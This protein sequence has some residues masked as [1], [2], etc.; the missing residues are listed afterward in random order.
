MAFCGELY[1]DTLP[2]LSSDLARTPRAGIN[3][4]RVFM[5]NNLHAD[6]TFALALLTAVALIGPGTSPARAYHRPEAE[7]RLPRP[8][9]QRGRHPLA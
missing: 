6:S 3:G 9:R 7:A 5:I 1:P 8:R 2:P 4:A